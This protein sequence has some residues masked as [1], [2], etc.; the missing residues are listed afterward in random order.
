MQV[1]IKRKQP[2]ARKRQA[3]ADFNDFNF[4]R[5]VFQS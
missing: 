4:Y 1:E 2:F 3:A 5:S